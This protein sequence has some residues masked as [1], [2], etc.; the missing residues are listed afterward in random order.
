MT[1]KGGCASGL[2]LGTRLTLTYTNSGESPAL[3][4]TE[5]TS[6]PR[7]A[8]SP[9]PQLRRSLCSSALG[10]FPGHGKAQSW[11]RGGSPLLGIMWVSHDQNVSLE[12]L[13]VAFLL[14]GTAT[15]PGAEFHLPP[16]VPDVGCMSS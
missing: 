12:S 9:E 13:T 1:L 11:N 3:A 8:Q 5:D 6:V 14:Q 2:V 15:L 16:Q 4:M 7:E 10:L